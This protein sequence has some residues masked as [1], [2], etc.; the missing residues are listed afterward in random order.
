MVSNY[1]PNPASIY[2]AVLS[3][4]ADILMKKG[5]C[6]IKNEISS[7]SP[8]REIQY[9]LQQKVRYTINFLFTAITDSY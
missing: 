5:D 2:V 8:T 4:C 6:Q 3:F 9:V 7:T 1:T